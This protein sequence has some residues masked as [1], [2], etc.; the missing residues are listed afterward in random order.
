MNF[1]CPQDFP[2][3]N[4]SSN[5]FQIQFSTSVKDEQLLIE[6]CLTD[7]MDCLGENFNV[8]VK[9]VV[10]ISNSFLMLVNT[11][12]FRWLSEIAN[13]MSLFQSKCT[14]SK[15]DIRIVNISITKSPTCNIPQIPISRVSYNLIAKDG[16]FIEKKKVCVTE[17][18]G[19]RVSDSVDF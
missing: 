13:R 17:N 5:K 8:T 16:V 15:I 1:S 2:I 18:Y 4:L 19:Q 10:N 11:P 6:A 14:S 12:E 3:E 9:P 7:L